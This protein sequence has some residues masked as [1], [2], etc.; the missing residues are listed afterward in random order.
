MKRQFLV[1]GQCHRLLDLHPELTDAYYYKDSLIMR[2]YMG[3]GYLGKL[4]F[5][6]V[7]LLDYCRIPQPRVVYLFY[8]GW[9]YVRGLR[10]ADKKPE[11]A[12]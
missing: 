3:L 9:H 12:A 1:G 11:P 7:R 6:L 8:L 10:V 4:F 5:P 2:C